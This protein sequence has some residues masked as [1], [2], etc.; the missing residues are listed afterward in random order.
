[1]MMM[2]MLLLIPPAL[3]PFL[4]RQEFQMGHTLITNSWG[5]FADS[6]RAASRP[7]GCS[8]IVASPQGCVYVC[9]CVYVCVFERHVC[10]KEM[11]SGHSSGPQLSV[12]AADGLTVALDEISALNHEILDNSVEL[13]AFVTL[14][15]AIFPKQ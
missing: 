4:Q 1:M 3:Q 15:E 8:L 12:C 13:A 6:T 2:M 5:R 11:S 10:V 7:H 14:R 9:M